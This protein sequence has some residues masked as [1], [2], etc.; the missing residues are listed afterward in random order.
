MYCVRTRMIY[1]IINS[2]ICILLIYYVAVQSDRPR[3]VPRN[4]EARMRNYANHSS[5]NYQPF[6]YIFEA[7]LKFV[8]HRSL[9]LS[10]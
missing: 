1:V 10:R 4:K 9:S 8:V 3:T 5:V 7:G 6:M 2:F